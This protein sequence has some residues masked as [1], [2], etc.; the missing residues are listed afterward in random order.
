MIKK[1]IFLT[2]S[3]FLLSSCNL[4]ETEVVYKDFT[5]DPLY[6]EYVKNYKIL[7]NQSSSLKHYLDKNKLGNELEKNP[8]SVK[9][10]EQYISNPENFV[11]QT[12]ILYKKGQL[13]KS[14]Y[15]ELENMPVNQRKKLFS[16]TITSNA[17]KSGNCEAQLDADL[18]ACRDGAYAAAAVCGLG[19]STLIGAL[20]CGA[21]VIV[22]K[23]I[24]ER[25]ALKSYEICKK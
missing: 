1:I 5:E 13:L 11:E 19:A 23:G 16:N 8:N 4:S 7:I 9:V 24:C 21:G 3:V 14:K 18:E 6:F 25:H 17:N 20:V 22:A 12:K 15:P 10:L 2:F